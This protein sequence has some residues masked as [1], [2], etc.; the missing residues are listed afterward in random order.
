MARSA[1]LI[2]PVR[3]EEPF[4]MVSAEAQ[5][6]GCPVIGFRRGA[7]TEVIEEGVTGASV[8]PGDIDGARRA[9]SQLARFDRAA[10]RRHAERR[11][12]VAPM[13]EAHL[14]LYERLAGA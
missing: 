11:L 12:D 8:D 4:G 9:V 2:F 10:C 5:A 3:W 7:L 13:I 1:A 6:T 14:A